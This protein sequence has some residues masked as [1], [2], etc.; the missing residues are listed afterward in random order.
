MS[1]FQVDEHPRPDTT[2]EALAKLKPAF[3]QGGTVTVGN[4]SG[5]NDG[6]AVLYGI[7][8]HPSCT[9][10]AV[11]N[12]S[13]REDLD[14]VEL[15]EALVSQS[16]ACTR[17]LGPD[18]TRANV[19]GGAI[20]LGHLLGANGARILTTLVHELRQRGGRY[21]LATMCIGV[22]RGVATIVEVMMLGL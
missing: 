22:G 12:R 21:G 7:G 3:T 13:I 16:L 10:S 5:I 14:L 9:Q 19:N 20:A 11:S 17:A 6:Y 4:S 1:Q 2:Y 15:N 8:T 18:P